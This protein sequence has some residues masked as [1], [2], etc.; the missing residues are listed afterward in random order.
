MEKMTY[1][2]IDNAIRKFTDVTYE[3]FD[4]HGYSTGFLG[5]MLGGVIMQLPASKQRELIR[6]LQETTLKYIGE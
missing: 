6:T 5:S 3:H 4:S 1:I 2:E